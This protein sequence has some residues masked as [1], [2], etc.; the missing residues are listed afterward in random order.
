[1]TFMDDISLNS[2]HTDIKTD[3]YPMELTLN[4][5]KQLLLGVSTLIPNPT[6]IL[7][8]MA[9]VYMSVNIKIIKL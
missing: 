4:P 1:M 5:E 3:I 2:Y 6:H 7:T 8:L 9:Q